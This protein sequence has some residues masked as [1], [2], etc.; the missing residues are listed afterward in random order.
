[1]T[2]EQFEPSASTSVTTRQVVIGAAVVLLAALA[3]AIH[4]AV[5]EPP[6][7]MRAR[8]A[9]MN[10]VIEACRQFDKPDETEL[11]DACEV[12]LEDE[13]PLRDTPE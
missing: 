8:R 6:D 2:N 3:F 10:S 9:V 7:A 4:S 13:N 5:E 11:D 12:L 1:M